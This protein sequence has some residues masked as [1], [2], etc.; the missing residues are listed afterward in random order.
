MK[1][2]C[3]YCNQLIDDTAANCPF[4]AAVNINMARSASSVPKTID[5]LKAFCQS[6]NLPL[7]KMRFFIGQDIKEPKAFGIYQDGNGNFVVY[8]NKADGTRAVR[9]SGT[10]EA[11]AVNELYQKLHSEVNAHRTSAPAPSNSNNRPSNSNRRPSGNRSSRANNSRSSS[12]LSTLFRIIV[13]SLITQGAVWILGVALLLWLSESDNKPSNGYYD[14]NGK[15][16]YSQ[17]GKWYQYDTFSDSW[18]DDI[19][20]PDSLESDYDDYFESFSYSDSYDA[21]DFSDSDYYQIQ[22]TDSDWDSDDWD[23]DDWSASSSWDDDDDWGS[24]W[25]SDWD[26]GSDWD[27]DW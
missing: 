14:Y 9:Y 2:K 13:K 4:C 24:S 1:I 18:L 12:L 26:S 16:Y 15:T 21:S 17:N 6:K 10:D 23:D 3:P 7:E 25:D 27:S 20:V 19:D 8:K 11:Y 5:E 22:T